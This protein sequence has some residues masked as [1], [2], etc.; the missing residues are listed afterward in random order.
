MD[1][2]KEIIAVVL[3]GRLLVDGRGRTFAK[4]PLWLAVLVGLS[5][6]QLAVV[7]AVLIV[8]FGMRVQVVRA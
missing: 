7:T 1:R 6:P 3:G 5:C 2:I 4:A 8:A